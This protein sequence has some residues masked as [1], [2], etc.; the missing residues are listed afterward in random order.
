ML[1]SDAGIGEPAQRE[2]DP[3]HQSPVVDRERARPGRWLGLMLCVP[4]SV[5]TPIV[6]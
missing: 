6:G 1:E 4:F 3:F 5:L 2:Q